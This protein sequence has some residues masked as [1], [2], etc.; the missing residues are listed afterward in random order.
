MILLKDAGGTVHSKKQQLRAGDAV[1]CVMN[2]QCAAMMGICSK[3]K[4]SGQEPVS[5]ISVSWFNLSFLLSFFLSLMD[6]FCFS[7]LF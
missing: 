7:S 1:P 6:Q 4:H 3:S 5:C 2:P